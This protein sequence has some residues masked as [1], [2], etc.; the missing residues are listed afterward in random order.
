M[1]IFHNKFELIILFRKKLYS[2]KE[3]GPCQLSEARLAL[4]SSRNGLKLDF[5]RVN[6]EKRLPYVT[7]QKKSVFFMFR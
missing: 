6:K 5:A 3:I 1:K 4:G 7:C 2:R